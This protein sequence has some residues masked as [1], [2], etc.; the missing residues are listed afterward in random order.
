MRRRCTKATWTSPTSFGSSAELNGTT[1][2]TNICYR[3][4]C[5][6][7]IRCTTAPVSSRSWP[8]SGYLKRMEHS[9]TAAML[10]PCVPGWLQFHCGAHWVCSCRHS[11]LSTATCG[12]RTW[13]RPC[14]TSMLKFGRTSR[15]ITR[16][17]ISFIHNSMKGS[18][19]SPGTQSEHALWVSAVVVESKRTSPTC[20]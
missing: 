19:T 20:K 5:A 2:H 7:Y 9:T 14:S 10:Q 4:R 3:M 16:E 17:K 8:G 18:H 11:M 1:V 12:C 6:V 15:L 13:T